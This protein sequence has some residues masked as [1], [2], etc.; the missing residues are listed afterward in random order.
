MKTFLVTLV[1]VFTTLGCEPCSEAP[2]TKEV[3]ANK[4]KILKHFSAASG[5]VQGFYDEENRIY[6]YTYTYGSA[7]SISCVHLP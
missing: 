4:P 2:A 3:A 6:C 1:L 5:Y 7:G